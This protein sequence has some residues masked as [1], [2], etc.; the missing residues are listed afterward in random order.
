MSKLYTQY[1]KSK[2]QTTLTSLPSSRIYFGIFLIIVPA[3]YWYVS[4]L[5]R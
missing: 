2:R 1:E 4:V 3:Y 5:H